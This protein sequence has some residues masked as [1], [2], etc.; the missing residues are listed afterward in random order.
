MQLKT[1]DNSQK[2]Y[3]SSVNKEHVL[4]S[5]N[6]LFGQMILVASSRN[7]NMKDVLEH[8]LGSLTWSLANG[9]GT[10]KKTNKASFARKLESMAG[11]TNE[12]KLPSA[13]MIDGMSLVQKM[14]GENHTFAELAKMLLSSVLNVSRGSTRVDVIFDVYNEISIKNAE[15]SRRSSDKSI[16]FTHILPGH[17]VH[18]WRR[19]LSCNDSKMKLIEFINDEWKTEPYRCQLENKNLFVTCNDICTKI[20]CKTAVNVE[21]LR[22]TH[23]EADTRLLLHSRHASAD[24]TSVI[25]ITE[26]TDVMVLCLAFQNEI[27]TNLFLRCGTSIRTRL[28]DI[29]TIANALGRNVCSGLIGLHSFTGC[30]TV[31]A[32][33]G[34]GKI[35]GLKLMTGN[36]TFQNAFA[37]LGKSWILEEHVLSILEEFTCQLYMPRTNIISVNE[38]R[39]Q[40]FRA[41][42]GGV[43]S[44]QLPPC[45]DCFTLHAKRAAY[46]AAIWQRSLEQMPQIPSPLDCDGWIFDD[47][48]SLVINWMSGLPAP[49]VVLKFLSCRCKQQCIL[50][51]CT[52]L[53]NG[54][55][56]TDACVLQECTNMTITEEQFHVE[57]DF[58]DDDTVDDQ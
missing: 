30:D 26:D 29:K 16:L 33:S 1:F 34:R 25:I 51:S 22:S 50:P 3:R 49:D 32:F 58:E 37:D 54:L 10:M 11:S 55:S 5:D 52:C 27:D 18:Q 35:G 7:L 24:F 8:P 23:E 19:L 38:M 42:N 46:Q 44:G 13:C 2:T 45:K 28:I 17:R 12:I 41:K 14:K 39:F 36:P 15:R 43:Q 31:S 48:N 47:E 4:K 9:D 57:S 6:K 21:E 53:S 56:C 20:T 40:L